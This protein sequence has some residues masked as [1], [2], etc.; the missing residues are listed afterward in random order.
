MLI[1]RI[2]KGAVFKVNPLQ[3]HVPQHVPRLCMSSVL[4]VLLEEAQEPVLI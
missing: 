3:A 1:L 2:K 4:V